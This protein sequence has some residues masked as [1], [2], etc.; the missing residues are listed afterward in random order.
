MMTVQPTLRERSGQ[1]Y[2][3]LLLLQ[4]LFPRDEDDDGAMLGA[5][6][7]SR[8]ASFGAAVR[9]VLDELTE[10]ARL[11]SLAPFPISEWRPGDSSDD[12]RW[13]A[14]TEV[15]RREVRALV[16]GYERLIAW[17]EEATRCQLELSALVAVSGSAAGQLPVSPEHGTSSAV[18]YLKAERVRLGRF[19]QELSFVLRRQ[20]D[21]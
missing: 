12:E 3:R 18:D 10:H 4:R 6:D 15:E 9:E 1:L 8:E 19:R 2:R 17:A 7:H 16:A 21:E 5:D 13:R 11:V 20:N 14:L